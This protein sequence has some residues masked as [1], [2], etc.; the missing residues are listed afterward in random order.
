MQNVLDAWA[1]A[2]E[3]LLLAFSWADQLATGLLL[4]LSGLLILLLPGSSAP[5][6]DGALP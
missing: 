3:R 2:G 4:A 1:C 6:V 5:A